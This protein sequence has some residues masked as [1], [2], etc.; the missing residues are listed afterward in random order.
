[1]SKIPQIV[2]QNCGLVIYDPVL[3]SYPLDRFFDINAHTDSDSFQKIDSGRGAGYFFDA[4]GIS[5]VFRYY[6]RG[7]LVGKVL[8]D[9]YLGVCG[10]SS[11]SFREFKLLWQLYEEGFSV[12]R[13]VAAL[14]EPHGIYYR[15]AL[16]TVRISDVDTLGHRLVRDGAEAVNWTALGHL[17]R[18]FHQR[19]VYHADLNVDNILLDG[20]NKMYLI[21]FDRA[22]IRRT[23]LW[24]KSNI[25]RLLRSI[26]KIR[27]NDCDIFK[28]RCW[29]RFLNAYNSQ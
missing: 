25:K 16:V 26:K 18:Q 6:R 28:D 13:P 27:Q 2:H 21:D 9:Q 15:A 8:Q 1:M 7:G 23:N 4:D 19:G 3:V 24:K 11:R 22:S 20:E 10:N 5:M 14:V 12:P 17:I 29:E